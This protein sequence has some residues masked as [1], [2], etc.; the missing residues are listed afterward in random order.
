MYFKHSEEFKLIMVPGPKDSGRCVPLNQRLDDEGDG[1]GRDGHLRGPGQEQGES[2][3]RLRLGAG[4][5]RHHRAQQRHEAG[6]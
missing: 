5:D 3:H 4:Q 6:Q 1:Q 2:L